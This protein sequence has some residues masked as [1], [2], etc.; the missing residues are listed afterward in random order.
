MMDGV[1]HFL[2]PIEKPMHDALV[3]LNAAIVRLERSTHPLVL[4]DPRG[5]WRERR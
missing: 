5:K 1:L 4:V 3:G 2:A